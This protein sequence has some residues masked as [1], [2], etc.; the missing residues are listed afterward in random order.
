MNS[1]A[2]GESTLYDTENVGLLHHVNQA[3][4]AHHLF[5]RDT[6]YMV[7]DGQVVIIDE[8]T[9]PRHGRSPFL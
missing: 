3:L 9:G 5:A 7:K 2:I 4:R 8:F 1:D 6:H